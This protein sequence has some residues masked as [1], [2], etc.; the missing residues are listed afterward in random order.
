M[1]ARPLRGHQG[2]REGPGLASEGVVASRVREVEAQGHL[3]EARGL[4]VHDHR[5]GEPVS[6]RRDRGH[7]Q[8]LLLRVPD[9]DEEVGPVQGIAAGQHEEGRTQ[10]RHLIDDGQS[11]IRRE[12]EG[13]AVGSGTRPAMPAG[14]S[15]GPGRLP[16][17]EEG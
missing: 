16:D 15:A 7:P 8:A 3:V 11:L 5:L 6:G 13:V 2:L 17:D 10:G 9:E 1:L 14:Q 12:L 4:E